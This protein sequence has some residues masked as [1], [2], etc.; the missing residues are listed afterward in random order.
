MNDMDKE[1][2]GDIICCD[3]KDEVSVYIN[4]MI[5]SFN[6]PQLSESDDGESFEQWDI[7]RKKNI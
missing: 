3:S 7:K 1:E 5:Q 4:M 2:T 6:I